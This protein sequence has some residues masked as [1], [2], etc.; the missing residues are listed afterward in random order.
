MTL[1][2]KV[3]EIIE[4]KNIT[5]VELSKMVG[6]DPATMSRIVNDKRVGNNT[7]SKFVK[8]FGDEFKQFYEYKN[9]KI[10]G[11]KFLPINNKVE[12]CSVECSRINTNNTSVAWVKSH[13]ERTVS[14]Q[15]EAQRFGRKAKV[16]K[17]SVSFAERENKARSQGVSYGQLGTTERLAQS[18]TMRESM[19][20]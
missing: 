15:T 11:N 4:E 16:K 1:Q 9:C 6:T 3:I 17:P 2:E 19:G 12:T 18:T 7:I 10:C 13:R 5:Y 8:K 20:L 14:S